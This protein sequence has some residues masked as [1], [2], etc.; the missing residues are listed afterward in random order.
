MRIVDDVDHSTHT[1]PTA[2]PIKQIIRIMT[3]LN[4]THIPSSSA[5]KGQAIHYNEAASSSSSS[6]Q[7]QRTNSTDS[8]GYPRRLERDQKRE[9]RQRIKRVVPVIPDLRFEQSYLLSIRPFLKPIRSADENQL[10]SSSKVAGGKDSKSLTTAAQD[11]AVF[12]WGRQ[13]SVDWAMVSWVTVRD[14]VRGPINGLMLRQ[15]ADTPHASTFR[16]SSHL[17]PRA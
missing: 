15:S 12:H 2:Q 4:P 13:V 14:Q 17:S 8:E 9:A 1:P 16:R 5:R 3:S 7:L 6:K 10:E 11:D